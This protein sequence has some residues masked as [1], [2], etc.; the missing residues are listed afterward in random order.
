MP[1]TDNRF[2]AD[3][4]DYELT[5]TEEPLDRYLATL[6][7]PQRKFADQTIAMRTEYLSNVQR[8]FSCADPHEA[9]T[10][11][12][13]VTRKTAEVVFRWGLLQHALT[14]WLERDT[15]ATFALRKR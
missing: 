14:H 15:T 6:D 9:M 3:L 8:M 10:Y 1:I 7:E 2:P 13:W 12:T 11:A 5:P 4:V